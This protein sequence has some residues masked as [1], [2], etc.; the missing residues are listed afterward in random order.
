MRLFIL[1][2]TFLSSV[3]F[4]QTSSAGFLGRYRVSDVVEEDDVR[5]GTLCQ[6]YVD[7]QGQT[8]Q[9]D[10]RCGQELL[11]YRAPGG[12]QLAMLVAPQGYDDVFFT[13]SVF[14]GALFAQN[15]KCEM[16]L[17][18]SALPQLFESKLCRAF[19]VDA[20]SSPE[21]SDYIFFPNMEP[22]P[23]Q[24]FSAADEAMA[25]E[26]VMGAMTGL[27]LGLATAYDI[28][29]DNQHRIPSEILINE[30]T[31]GYVYFQKTVLKNVI[32]LNRIK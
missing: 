30:L 15:R 18:A 4:A 31:T 11:V 2:V 22:V 24:L 16:S 3:T 14:R 28:Q 23:G 12:D 27:P 19:Q 26:I 8:Q 9:V 32:H 20:T 7:P 29:I 5:Q 10:F 17:K 6:P 25:R 21:V 1:T 13:F